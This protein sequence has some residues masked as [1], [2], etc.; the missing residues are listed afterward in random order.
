MKIEIS[1]RKGAKRLKIR[2]VG[3]IEM[4]VQIDSLPTD[5]DARPTRC[6]ELFKNRL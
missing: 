4:S 3:S 5:Q 2:Y 6:M 1:T